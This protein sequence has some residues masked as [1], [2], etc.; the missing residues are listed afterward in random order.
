MPCTMTQAH[1]EIFALVRAALTTLAVKY[2]DMVAPAGFPPATAS[3]GRVSIG[4]TGEERPPPL[5]A[6]PNT[7][8]Y[9]MEGLL[10]V[11]LYAL[12]GD[13]RRA[14]QALGEAVLAGF[15]GQTTAGGVWFRNL[16]VVPVGADGAW[17]HENALIEYRYDSLGG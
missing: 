7:R 8:R 15:R 13:G 3:W 2:P 6:S 16:R 5:V 17:W 9:H 12:A 11:E 4:D 14:S 1:N 10:T